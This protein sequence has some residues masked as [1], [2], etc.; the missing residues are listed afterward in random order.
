MAGMCTAL[1]TPS[2]SRYAV[3]NNSLKV[4][5]NE[6]DPAEIRFAQKA[7]VF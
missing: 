1:I 6:M 7:L 5:S 3:P 4:L 2:L